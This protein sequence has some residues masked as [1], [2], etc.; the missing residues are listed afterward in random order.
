MQTGKQGNRET[1]YRVYSVTIRI[2]INIIKKYG[3]HS[4][5]LLE[6]LRISIEYHKK[7][8]T[9][10][11]EGRYWTYD[12]IDA[13]SKKCGLSRDSIRYTIKNLKKHEILITGNF[14]P[15]KIDRTTWYT[16]DEIKLL[17]SLT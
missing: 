6:R 9:H 16:I 11:Y 2:K 17:E 8:N 3:S 4:A 7:R 14:N 15:N 12:T 13:L 10:F 5:I 1:G